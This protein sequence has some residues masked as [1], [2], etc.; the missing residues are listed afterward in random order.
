MS[1]SV[2][3]VTPAA[4]GSHPEADVH[5]SWTILVFQSDIK[6]HHR[7]QIETIIERNI[8]RKMKRTKKRAFRKE[9]T[10]LKFRS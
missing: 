2:T 1:F 8:Y 4:F 9:D 3:L 5:S 7:T 10:A 6:F